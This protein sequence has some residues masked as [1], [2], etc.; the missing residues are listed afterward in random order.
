MVVVISITV[1]E[2]A[3][4]S[5]IVVTE[6]GSAVEPSGVTVVIVAVATAT[7]CKSVGRLGR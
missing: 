5:A 2:V 7:D 6:Q 1:A 3:G 4:S